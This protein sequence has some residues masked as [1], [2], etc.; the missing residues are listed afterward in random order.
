MRTELG[1]I[2]GMLRTTKSPT[3]PLQRELDRTGKELGIAVIVIAAVVVATLLALC[4]A[5]DAKTGVQV[6]MFGVALAVAGAGVTRRECTRK[7]CRS[8]TWKCGTCRR[9]KAP[10]S[11]CGWTF[12]RSRTAG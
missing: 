11:C 12:L 9:P 2:A 10:C 1:K 4:S 6:L 5:R 3:T 7:E 8:C